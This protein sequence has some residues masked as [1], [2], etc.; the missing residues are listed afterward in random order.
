LFLCGLNLTIAL[1]LFRTACRVRGTH[2]LENICIDHHEWKYNESCV[3][4]HIEKWLLEHFRDYET[5]LYDS[6]ANCEL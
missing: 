5:D 4:E 1:S 6:L 3:P 2:R